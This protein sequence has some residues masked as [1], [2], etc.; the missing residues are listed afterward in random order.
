M[1]EDMDYAEQQALINLHMTP[2]VYEQQDY[3]RFNEILL[4]K[5]R[6][7]REQDIA[8]IFNEFG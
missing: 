1:V 8:S 5:S 4:A 2:E 3:Y 6:D 7:D